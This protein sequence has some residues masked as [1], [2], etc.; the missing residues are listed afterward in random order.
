MFLFTIYHYISSI[1]G[2][3]NGEQGNVRLVNGSTALEGRVEVCYNRTW[4][5]VCDDNWGQIDANVVCRQLGFS[6]SGTCVLHKIVTLSNLF[7]VQIQV[8]YLFFELALVRVVDQFLWTILDAVEQRLNYCSVLQ[9]RLECTTVTI[10]KMPVQSVLHLFL[11]PVSIG[12]IL[13]S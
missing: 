13:Y 1:T 9:M 12:I 4:G 10:L 3:T 6:G 11:H 8:L 2:C 5:T 7:C